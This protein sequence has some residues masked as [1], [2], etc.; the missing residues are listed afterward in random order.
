MRNKVFILTT[1]CMILFFACTKKK[2]IF[3]IKKK[4][5]TF[6]LPEET[7]LRPYYFQYIDDGLDDE[8]LLM[9]SNID[10]F[11]SMYSFKDSNPINLIPL[12]EKINSFYFH[13]KD[14]ILVDLDGNIICQ[15]IN[16]NIIDIISLDYAPLLRGDIKIIEV[17]Y[18]NSFSRPLFLY[19]NNIVRSKIVSPYANFYTSGIKPDSN[20]SNINLDFLYGRSG[21]HL[22][23]LH[24]DSLY[25]N[26]SYNHYSKRYIDNRIGII[27]NDYINKFGLI[28]T[29]LFTNYTFNKRKVITSLPYSHNIYIYDSI[30]ANPKV[31]NCKSKYINRF[32]EVNKKLS[33]RTAANEIEKWLN[34]EPY[35]STITY[36]KYNDVYYR[37]VIHRKKDSKIRGAS[38]QIIKSD[39]SSFK[40]V[41][42]NSNDYIANI[43]IPTKNGLLIERK[44][45]FNNNFKIMFDLFNIKK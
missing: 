40:E 6:I 34:Q 19:N 10:T 36:D 32:S 26:K 41:Y 2:E 31:Y 37:A 22:I 12:R 18:I 24:T 33:L 35:Y 43:I 20:L 11:I 21:I 15:N 30:V 28:T 3:T 9:T 16:G 8:Y 25:Y 29:A 23:P 44:A 42:I 17:D 5:L 45:A 7:S 14:T 39:F 4:Y 13:N 27:P 38:I 1:L